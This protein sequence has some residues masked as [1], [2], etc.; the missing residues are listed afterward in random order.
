MSSRIGPGPVFV[1]ESLIF[2][3]R[4]QVYAGRALF[5]LALL[6][7]LW[8]AWWSNLNG[9]AS[10]GSRTGPGRATGRRWR[11]P[12]SRSSWRWPASSS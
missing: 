6:I 9:P 7:G 8:A 11:T 10:S 1:Y 2:A 12:A 3:R 5:V 4:W